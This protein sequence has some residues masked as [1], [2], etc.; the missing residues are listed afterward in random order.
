MEKLLIPIPIPWYEERPA[1]KKIFD[2]MKARQQKQ[3]PEL[4]VRVLDDAV[5]GLN[6]EEDDSSDRPIDSHDVKPTV[7]TKN[8]DQKRSTKLVPI[9]ILARPKRQFRVLKYSGFLILVIAIFFSALLIDFNFGLLVAGILATYII[10]VILD[11]SATIS[12]QTAGQRMKEKI[13]IIAGIPA[14]LLLTGILL[15][16]DILDQMLP[17]LLFSDC[18][19]ALIYIFIAYATLEE[20]IIPTV[21]QYAKISEIDPIANEIIWFTNPTNQ[22]SMRTFINEKIT[23][24]IDRATDEGIYIPQTAGANTIPKLAF[25]THSFGSIIVFDFLSRSGHLF[26]LNQDKKPRLTDAKDPQLLNFVLSFIVTMGSPLPLFMVND[27]FAQPEKMVMRPTPFKR[28]EIN[29]FELNSEV[30]DQVRWENYYDSEDVLARKFAPLFE[31][32]FYGEDDL[33]NP[34]NGKTTAQIHDYEVDL[35]NILSAHTEYWRSLSTKT[36]DGKNLI[37]FTNQ[38]IHAVERKRSRWKNLRDKF[39]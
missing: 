4:F 18:I 27:R 21:A 15:F 22:E 8:E 11:I 14:L 34:S 33:D 10:S 12:E 36:I 23:E 32:L 19:L 9:D 38:I 35:G 1:V 7:D 20:D 17:Y 28:D 30:R 24:T 16:Y 6:N 13:I 29:E 2:T 3:Y 25:I 5:Y 39:T 37:Q 26:R 31:K